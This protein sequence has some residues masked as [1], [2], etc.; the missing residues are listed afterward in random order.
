MMAV[1]EEMAKGK[2]VT[3][4]ARQHINRRVILLDTMIRVPA[5]YPCRSVSVSQKK[6]Q[7]PG[8]LK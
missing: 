2:T 5:A 3:L 6:S 1:A 7:H 4:A 8:W